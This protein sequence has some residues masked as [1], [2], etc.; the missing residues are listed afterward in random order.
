MYETHKPS[1]DRPDVFT[2]N[3]PM[4]D[5]DEPTE[6]DQRETDQTENPL[7]HRNPHYE[8]KTVG[9]IKKQMAM[10]SMRGR[11]KMGPRTFFGQN[12]LYPGGISQDK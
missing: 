9:M 11:A 7:I 10:R 12:D 3:L 5:N 2:G 8:M 1:V 6:N 4:G